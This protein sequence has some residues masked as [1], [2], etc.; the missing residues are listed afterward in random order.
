MPEEPAAEAVAGHQGPRSESL[1]R[2]VTLRLKEWWND[3]W[4]VALESLDPKDQLLWRMNKRVMRVPTWSPPGHLGGIFLSDSEKA[5]DLA[6]SLKT[7]FQL[8]TPS[9][10]SVIEMVDVA[11]R[12]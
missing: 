4:S 9:F 3:K 10:P 2:S 5:E 6:D 7:Q 8:V 12:S 11:L 1:Q